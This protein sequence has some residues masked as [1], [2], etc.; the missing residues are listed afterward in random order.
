MIASNIK[1]VTQGRQALTTAMSQQGF[2]M[3]DMNAEWAVAEA[4]TGEMLK[5]TSTARLLAKKFAG[6][7]LTKEEG[8]VFEKA[9]QRISRRV[10]YIAA[11]REQEPEEKP[12]LE[13]LQTANKT[14]PFLKQ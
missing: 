4:V 1:S 14:N 13:R 10:M 8:I 5:P 11:E 12:A 6:K 7:N 3:L 9:M 2:A